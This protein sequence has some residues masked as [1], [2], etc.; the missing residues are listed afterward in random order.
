[1][2][3]Y[4]YFYKIENKING[5]FYYGIHKT[6][7]LNDGYLGSGKRIL[8]AIKKYGKENFNKE[9]LMF[10]NTYN[11]ALN[12]E[13]EIVTEELILDSSCYN[14][15]LGGKSDTGFLRKGPT[16]IDKKTGKLVKPNNIDEYYKLFNIGN[17]FGSGKNKGIYKSYDGK[18]YYL[19]VN[20]NAIKE[21]DLHGLCYNM[22]LCKNKDGK[23][24]WVD[25]NDKRY[26]NGQLVLFWINKKHSDE[27]KKKIGLKNSIKQKGSRN[28]QYG[29]CWITNEKENK[30]M[31]KGNLVPYGWKLGRKIKILNT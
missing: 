3:K 5:N 7:N 1:M 14:L 31:C 26:L 10:F 13:S 6:S 22:K 8:Y 19:N 20:D 28:S 27:T 18:I 30:K 4:I 17:Y 15:A 25:K 12:Y 24:F 16:L 21:L 29:T 11:E 2:K 23:V 9:I